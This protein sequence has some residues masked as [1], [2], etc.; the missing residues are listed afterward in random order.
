MHLLPNEI[1]ILPGFLSDTIE[2]L[3][4]EEVSFVLPPEIRHV[5]HTP[6]RITVSACADKYRVV[7]AVDAAPGPWDSSRVPHT[8]EPMDDYASPW[9]KE[10]WLCWPERAAKTNVML[11]CLAWTK[12]Y[13]SGNVF[14]LDPAED[15]AGKNVKTKIIPMFRES[16]KLSEC[17]S[18]RADDTGKSLIAFQDGTYLFPAHSNSARSMSNFF[19]LHNFGNEVDK[20]PPMTGPEADPITLIRKRGRDVP[21]SR[22]MFSSTPAGRHI[23]KGTFACRKVKQRYS[24]CPHCKEL[25]LMD[26]DHLVIPDGATYEQVENED[27]AV[28]YACNA[29][30]AV[31][32]EEDRRESYISGRWIVTKGG[33]KQR[34]RT[35]GY[36]A[37]ALPF[38]MIP[39]SEYCGKKLRA[40]QGD[41]A[42]KIAFVNGYKVKDYVEEI[43]EAP[44]L[45]GLM[46]RAEAYAPIVPMDAGILTAGVDVQMDRLEIEVVAWGVGAESWGIDYAVLYGDTRLPEVWEQ[47]DGY[48]LQTWEH[49]TGEPLRLALVFIDSGYIPNQVAKFCAPRRARGVYAIKGASTEKAPE[50]Q[51]PNRQRHG[52]VTCKVYN[53]GVNRLKT[54]MFAYFGLNQPGPGYCHL[55]DTYPANWY[56]MLQAEHV[57][58]KKVGN[59][60]CNV[61]VKKSNNSRNESIDLRVYA[62]AAMMSIKGLNIKAQIAA[63]KAAAAEKAAPKP[64]P[65][66]KPGF[67]TRWK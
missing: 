45:D 43:G 5:L 33:D 24:R 38:P 19:G 50:I 16:E 49:A 2:M 44:E 3:D 26:D 8:I 20:Y 58:E 17:L 64:I 15:D 11:N 65:P 31:W 25:I 41:L 55:P 23:Y 37:S 22:F 35:I 57:V 4:G 29:C 7:T 62:M 54:Q 28:G 42:A 9:V 67:A 1:E 59:E 46:D 53:L 48:L 12:L 66:R 56:D 51:G 63:L 32:D 39:L 52:S 36:H 60:T 14:W 34:A 61:W 30:G 47:L 13:D 27:V 21:G 6:E 40:E 10:I 18:P